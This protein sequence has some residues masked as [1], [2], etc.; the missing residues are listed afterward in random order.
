M[1]RLAKLNDLFKEGTE[2]PLESPDGTVTLVWINKLSSF[3]QE[4]A[5]HAGRVARSRAMLAIKEVGSPEYDLFRGNIAA[6]SRDSLIEAIIGRRGDEILAGALRDIRSKP[7]EEWA[8][9]LDVLEHS[10]LR[11]KEDDDPEVLMVARI[12]DEYQAELARLVEEAQKDLRAELSELS[13][14]RLREEYEDL[15]V[16][17]RG[18]QAF[19][20]A[21]SLHELYFCMRECNGVAVGEGKYTHGGCQHME[22]FLD[23]PSEAKFLPEAV[24]TAVVACY[25]RVMMPP[26][27]AR[28]TDALPSSSESS[29]PSSKPEDSA[30][31]GPTE[32][33]VEPEAISSLQ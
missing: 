13:Q 6:S 30:A 7:E 26:E 32:T 27:L 14:E 16:E 28:F 19:L 25:G 22:L 8:E 31:S 23:D 4:E 20:N 17:Q 5:N 10:D 12:A 29:G 18:L 3:Q 15:Y 21:R 2:L 24:Q 33:P 11:D 9:R 1:G